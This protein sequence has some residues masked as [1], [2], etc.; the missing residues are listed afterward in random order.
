MPLPK[1]PKLKE[2]TTPLQQRALIDFKTGNL[3]NP[4]K[5]RRKTTY[6]NRID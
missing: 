3:V 1:Q 2:K 6:D 4:S 5:S